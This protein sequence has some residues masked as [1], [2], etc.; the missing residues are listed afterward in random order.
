MA[1]W[2]EQLS[3]EYRGNESLSN[4]PDI[5]T[6]AKSYLD[7]Q[8]HI[9]GSIRI[10]SEDAG[11]EDWAAFNQKLSDQ[12]PTLINLPADE[13]EAHA[14]LLARLGRPDT[15]EGY[16][17][18][19]MNDDFRNWAFENGFT[20]KQ[21]ASLLERNQ[22]DLEAANTASAEA[23]REAFDGLKQ[24][25][26]FAYDK[27]LASANKAIEAYA[28]ESAVQYIMDN[29]LNENAAF[30]KMMANIGGQLGEEPAG[31]IGG[32]SNF[33]LSPDEAKMQIAEITNNPKHPYHSGQK[34]AVAQMSKL[35]QQAHP[36]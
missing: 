15:A 36:E 13:A 10:P 4:I 26:G 31:N 29:K 14:A 1:E 34:D 21:I 33:T 35:F 24:E 28:D 12:V 23:A 19:G 25:W 5:D 16:T 8:Q 6:L 32:G 20:N 30:I 11:Q 7:A 3:D 18:E 9:G 22:G 27:N 2:H 17:Q